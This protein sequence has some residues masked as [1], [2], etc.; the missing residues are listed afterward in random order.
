MPPI[1]ANGTLRMMSAAC[2]SESEA[3]EEQQEDQ[4]DRDRHDDHQPLHRPLLVLELA[5]PRH[6]VPRRA[7]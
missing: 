2:L 1:S 4:T 6:E 5:S 3:R 7:A